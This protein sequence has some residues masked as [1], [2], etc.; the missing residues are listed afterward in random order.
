MPIE[1]DQ[2]SQSRLG[3]LVRSSSSSHGD[4]G[5]LQLEDTGMMKEK[6]TR[7]GIQNMSQNGACSYDWKERRMKMTGGQERN[8]G[9]NVFIYI[10]GRLIII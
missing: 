1:G 5:C 4:L 8:N 7:F 10:I 3:I 2:N 6:R 9:Y